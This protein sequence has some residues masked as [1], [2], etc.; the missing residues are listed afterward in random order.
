RLAQSMVVDELMLL[1][2]SVEAAVDVRAIAEEQ[3]RLLAGQI[4][5]MRSHRQP[6]VGAHRHHIRDRIARFQKRDHN[7]DAGPKPLPAPPGSPIGSRY[8]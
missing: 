2:T 7:A 4:S 6:Q 1:A 5:K 8:R 3:L